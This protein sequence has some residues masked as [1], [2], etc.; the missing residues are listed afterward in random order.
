[1]PQVICLNPTYC[2]ELDNSHTCFLP[3]AG[4]EARRLEGS[5]THTSLGAR[6]WQL[7]IATDMLAHGIYL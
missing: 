4:C 2:S 6:N 3:G 7:L 1:M 5:F